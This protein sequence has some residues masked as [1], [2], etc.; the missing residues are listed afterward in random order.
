MRSGSGSEMTRNGIGE[1][2]LRVFVNCELGLRV[3]GGGGDGDGLCLWG[4]V[5]FIIQRPGPATVTRSIMHQ[6][7]A[8]LPL[9]RRVMLLLRSRHGLAKQNPEKN[10]GGRGN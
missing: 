1:V 5:P 9:S 10:E 8:F 2:I 4:S 6:A 7:S 3:G